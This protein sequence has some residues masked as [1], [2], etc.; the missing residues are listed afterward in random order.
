MTASIAFQA[1]SPMMVTFDV[2]GRAML[3]DLP[4]DGVA[5]LLYDLFKQ[6]LESIKFGI[7]AQLVGT[8]EFSLKLYAQMDAI[9]GVDA[10]VA[11]R[12]ATGGGPMISQTVRYT[13]L[14]QVD[15]VQELIYALDIT[16]RICVEKCD[17]LTKR[18]LYLTGQVSARIITGGPAGAATT[19]GGALAL[20]VSDGAWYNSFGLP[21]LHISSV[22]AGV[23][24]DPKTFP[25]PS[26]VLVGAAFCVGAKVNCQRKDTDP[27]VRD[28]ILDWKGYASV[29]ANVPANNYF[30]MLIKKYTLRNV[31]NAMGAVPGIGALSV[32]LSC[33]FQRAAFA[34][35][36]HDWPTELL[37]THTPSG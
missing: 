16:L 18:F 36:A 29:D 20:S 10:N 4:V 19:M 3:P 25:V 7:R 34:L 9:G 24:F 21:F 12:D 2:N 37:G 23:Q 15:Q 5:K 6:I 22:V 33:A 32:L 30:I 11:I 13:G 1:A 27:S 14:F 26:S 17:T 31:L 35:R 28:L 8:A